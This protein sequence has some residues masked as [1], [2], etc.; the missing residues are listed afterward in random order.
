M[1]KKRAFSLIELLIVITIIG[2][3]AAIAAPAYKSYQGKS[4][5]TKLQSYSTMLIDKISA[6]NAMHGYF[7][8]PAQM[9]YVLYQCAGDPMCQEI[10]PQDNGETNTGVMQVNLTG[11]TTYTGNTWNG[12]SSNTCSAIFII[13]PDEAIE[14][15]G[16]QIQDFTYLVYEENGVVQKV[17][18]YDAWSGI[19][20][21]YTGDL[22][23]SNC[24][25]Y[26]DPNTVPM[27]N[28]LEFA[29]FNACV[30]H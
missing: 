28:A 16:Y 19:S 8:W 21:L 29:A 14:V 4:K 11:S 24:I 6:Y 22:G 23:I 3:I 2:V 25:N 17:C 15:G 20:G 13:A 5:L 30:S 12:L 9:G 18:T 27:L 7:P 1:N 10:R 26:N